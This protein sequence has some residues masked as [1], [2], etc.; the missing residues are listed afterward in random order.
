MRSKKELYLRICDL[1]Y[2]N[3]EMEDLI[4]ELIVRITKL[5]NKTKKEEK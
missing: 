2:K 3:D 4:E 5:E 1:E